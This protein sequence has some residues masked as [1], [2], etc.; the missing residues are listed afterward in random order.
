VPSCLAM[1]GG[2]TPATMASVA[3]L[4]S[5]AY[6]RRA[7]MVDRQ[8]YPCPRAGGKVARWRCRCGAVVASCSAAVLVEVS[9]AQRDSRPIEAPLAAVLQRKLRRA[10]SG[11]GI[12]RGHGAKRSR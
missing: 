11:G 7:L 9:G 3:K 4:W 8:A 2:F 6:A 12:R 10:D 5:A 1:N